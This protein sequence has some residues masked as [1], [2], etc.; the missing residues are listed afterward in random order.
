[1]PKNTSLNCTMPELTNISVG[2]LPGTKELDATMVWPL[3]AKKSRKVLRISAT[4]K[5]M[6]GWLMVCKV[7]GARGA[8]VRM[9]AGRGKPKIIGLQA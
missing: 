6:V 2:S 8:P 5:G 9:R 4:V 7:V 1:M 3:E